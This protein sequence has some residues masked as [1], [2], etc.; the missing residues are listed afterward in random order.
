MAPHILQQLE[1]PLELFRM[2]QFLLAHP[3]SNKLLPFQIGTDF[4]SSMFSYLSLI[5]TV[6]C[7]GSFTRFQVPGQSSSSFVFS[8]RVLVSTSTRAFPCCSQT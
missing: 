1:I 6:H 3:E 8:F 5:I 2:V 4:S 7:P